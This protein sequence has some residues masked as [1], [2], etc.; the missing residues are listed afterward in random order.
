MT[1]YLDSAK[2]Y[3]A[4]EAAALGWVQGVTTN[5]TL[6]AQSEFS[7]EETLQRIFQ[8][9]G[10]P[11][12]YQLVQKELPSMLKEAY[13][14]REILDGFLVAKIPACETGFRAAARLSQEGIDCAITTIYSP[15]Q[16]MLA[17]AVGAKY[18]I[19]YYHR[20]LT[21]LENGPDFVAQTVEVLS[22]SSTL[23]LAASLK[24]V[25]EVTQARL[26]GIKHFTL[27]INVLK[28]LSS[29]PLSEQ[30]I[31]DFDLKGRGLTL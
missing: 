25:E 10:R 1:F 7:P 19:I 14:A 31:Q 11:V 2:V 28:S 26:T 8:A 29:V 30:T 16:A 23:L 12:F 21:L 20:A 15:A 3:E 13:R 9:V 24:S 4:Q 27:P 22:N 17:E 5:P 18:A 6:L